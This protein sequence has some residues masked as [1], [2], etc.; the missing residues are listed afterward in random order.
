MR[1]RDL[2]PRPLALTPRPDPTLGGAAVKVVGAAL[3][4]WSRAPCEA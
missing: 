1:K 3:H 2:C 4:V